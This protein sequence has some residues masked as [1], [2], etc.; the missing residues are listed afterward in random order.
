MTALKKLRSGIIFGLLAIATQPTIAAANE[1]AAPT[2]SV[3][4]KWTFK[5]RNNPIVEDVVSQ[6]DATSITVQRTYDHD[7]ITTHTLV[8]TPEWNEIVSRIGNGREF[9][10]EPAGISFKFPL[11]V[12][13]VWK[14]EFRRDFGATGSGF[15]TRSA[16]VETLEDVSVPAGNFKAYRIQVSTE[17]RSERTDGMGKPRAQGSYEQTYWYVPE[18]NRIVK[19]FEDGTTRLELIGVIK[20]GKS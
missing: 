1:A 18:L 2:V 15:Q 8:F 3:G 20:A 16:K 14:S 13:D 4:D 6:V 7:A 11:K 19:H 12:G 5:G 17:W 9:K 10:D